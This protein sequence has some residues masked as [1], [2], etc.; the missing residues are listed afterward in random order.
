M[1]AASALSPHTH[2]G[3]PAAL[4]H[5][6]TKTNPRSRNTVRGN[7][8]LGLC[9]LMVLSVPQPND[10]APDH[11]GLEPVRPQVVT[12]LSL[13]ANHGIFYMV[14]VGKGPREKWLCSIVAVLKSASRRSGGIGRRKGLKIPRVHKART[15]SIPVSGTTKRRNVNA[16]DA[17]Q[18]LTVLDC[19]KWYTKRPSGGTHFCSFE[20]LPRQ[21]TTTRRYR[22]YTSP[23]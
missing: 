11:N 4:G 6:N 20:D 14:R 13:H 1:Q 8:H 18:R 3:M 12:L 2:P 21:D 17:F 9:L 22:C 10:S 5:R 23:Y 7:G 16:R 19:V 15:G